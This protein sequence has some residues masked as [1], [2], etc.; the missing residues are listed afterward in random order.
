MG[1]CHSSHSAFCAEL[2]TKTK[3]NMPL[4][5]FLLEAQTEMPSVIM[6][7]L[8]GVGRQG[9][10]VAYSLIREK[11]TILMATCHQLEHAFEGLQ[12]N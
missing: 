8:T 5:L 2:C 9:V 6:G 10:R 7:L 3:G 1:H 4:G 12:K 11:S